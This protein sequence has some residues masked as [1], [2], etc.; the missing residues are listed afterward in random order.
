MHRERGASWAVSRDE[1]VLAFPELAHERLLGLMPQFL[2]TARRLGAPEASCWSLLPT[3]P[4]A[5]G[6]ELV[7]AGFREGWQAHWMAIEVHARPSSVFPPGVEIGLAPATWR[8]TSLPW[9]G[10]RVAAIRSSLAT[11]RPRRV[12]HLGAWREGRP[13]GHALVNV[14]T[15]RLGVSGI[16]D[17][18]VAESERRRGIGSALIVAALQLAGAQGCAAATLNATPEGE[19]LF[20]ALGFQSVGVAQTWW[21]DLAER[22]AG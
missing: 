8:P 5:L 22:A 11:A 6:S 17:V 12:W 2:S 13:V 9:D 1:A 18:G 14:T 7:A 4:E 15:G 20:S 16:Y 19:L 10:D 3:E 21:L